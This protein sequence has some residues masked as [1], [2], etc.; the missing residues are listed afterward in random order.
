MTQGVPPMPSWSGHPPVL[1]EQGL[2]WPVGRHRD[3]NQEIPSRTEA[4]HPMDN[5]CS[6]VVVRRIGTILLALVGSGMIYGF[7]YTRG[8][9]SARRDCNLETSQRLEAGRAS[10][11][12]LIDVAI[13]SK[14]HFDVLCGGHD[15]P[16]KG[17]KL[18]CNYDPQNDASPL[19]RVVISDI[20]QILQ[21]ARPGTPIFNIEPTG[22]I[23]VSN[24]NGDVLRL[25]LFKDFILMNPDGDRENQ[26]WLLFDVFGLESRVRSLYDSVDKK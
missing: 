4:I 11:K 21:D 20:V 10:E 23:L 12:P 17:K 9:S 24:P 2:V 16:R 5:Q 18:D 19:R 22:T 3:S 26:K 25:R 8:Y 7:A 6:F 14:F 15:D 1:A 13:N